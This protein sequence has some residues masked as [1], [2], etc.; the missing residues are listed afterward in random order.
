LVTV[1][2]VQGVLALAAIVAG[3]C[4]LAGWPVGLIVAGVLLAVDRLT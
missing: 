1:R 2:A 4:F 3:V